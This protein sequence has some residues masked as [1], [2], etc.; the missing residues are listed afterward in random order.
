MSAS[1]GLGGSAMQASREPDVKKGLLRET[2]RGQPCL[3]FTPHRL[4]L[5]D[6]TCTVGCESWLI[7]RPPQGFPNVY[8]AIVQPEHGQQ[9]H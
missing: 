3:L 1:P 8:D 7:R 4:P 2:L 5:E 9:E 6:S